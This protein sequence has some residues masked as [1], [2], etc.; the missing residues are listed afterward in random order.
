M[1]NNRGTRVNWTQNEKD[2]VQEHLGK[3]LRLGRCP[4]KA[5]CMK[6]KE[7]TRLDKRDWKGIKFFVKNQITSVARKQCKL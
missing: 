2:A 7:D 5:D 6:A 3:F 1:S 4:G